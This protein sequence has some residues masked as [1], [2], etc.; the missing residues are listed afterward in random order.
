MVRDG[1]SGRAAAGQGA[2]LRVGVGPAAAEPEARFEELLAYVMDEASLEEL[3][4][5]GLA[6]QQRRRLLLRGSPTG[7]AVGET[8]VLEGATPRYVN[9]L[10]GTVEAVARE[11][12]SVL[13]SE[14]CTVELR[15]VGA[16]RFEMAPGTLRYL[17]ARIPM[18]WCRVDPDGG[19]KGRAARGERG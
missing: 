12:C 11:H 16:Q 7:V 14:Q 6:V 9:G 17:L 19:P 15:I 4:R 8:V 18:A 3:G 13:L 10:T 1:Q 5:L 2:G